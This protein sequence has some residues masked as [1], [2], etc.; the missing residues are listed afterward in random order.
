M[1]QRHS[2][3]PGASAPL[4]AHAW[5]C[6]GTYFPG[7]WV[8]GQHRHQRLR[9]PAVS[10]PSQAPR[11]MPQRSRLQWDPHFSPLQTE[12]VLVRQIRIHPKSAALRKHKT[13]TQM[14]SS[15]KWTTEARKGPCAKPPARRCWCSSLLA[16][17]S[18]GSS[19]LNSF[20]TSQQTNPVVSPFPRL[21]DPQAFIPVFNL[22]DNLKVQQ[23]LE[24]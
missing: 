2:L 18:P 8:L 22:A 13:K 3:S 14:L 20:C 10:G 1:A 16:T 6:K 7:L 17:G 9:S 19:F 24:S 15:L 5:P 21:C 11:L 4:P 23:L 12:T